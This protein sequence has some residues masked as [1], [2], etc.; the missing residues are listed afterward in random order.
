MAG[1]APTGF[2]AAV[3][4]D[5][6]AELRARAAPRNFARGQALMHVGQVPRDVFFLLAGRVKVTATTPAGRTVLLAFRGPGD[7]I[8]DL[9]ALDDE[10]RSATVEALEPVQALV[11]GRDPFRTFLME[12]PA[13]ALTLL[14]ELSA[15]LRDADAK[16][17][18]LA[19]YTT[20]GRVAFCLLELSERFGEDGDSL[21]PLSQEELASW[22]GASIESVGRALQTMRKL[23][24]IET[25]RRAIRVLDPVALEGATA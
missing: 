21:L 2:W 14:R 4:A 5:A 16:R 17:V 1:G 23:G 25:R 3:G 11:M 7:L 19:A 6:A 15:R 8:G 13:V 18:Q 20:V 10:P 12:R 9:A 22:A 24:W